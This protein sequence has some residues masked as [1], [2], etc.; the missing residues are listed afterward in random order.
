MILGHGNVSC[1][2]WLQTRGSQTLAEAAQESWVLG[3]VTGFN[4]YA[5]R[6]GNILGG[7]DTDG[8]FS[9]IDAYCQANPLDSLFHA[10]GA[11]VR[12]LEK[13]AHAGAR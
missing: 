5:V 6:S 11:L 4:N 9:W 1:G 10:S 3:F 2:T 7:T 13:R 8:L 12:E